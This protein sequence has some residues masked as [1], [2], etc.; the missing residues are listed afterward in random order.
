MTAPAPFLPIE[1]RRALWVRLW[2]ETLLRP[3]DMPADNAPPRSQCDDERDED[4]RKP[5]PLYS[6]SNDAD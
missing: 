2:R 1:T 4:R 6:Q 3:R 5:S